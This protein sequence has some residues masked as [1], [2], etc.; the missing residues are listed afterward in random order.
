MMNKAE[1][2]KSASV[3]VRHVVTIETIASLEVVSFTLG[4]CYFLNTASK[5][6]IQ[7]WRDVITVIFV[8]IEDIII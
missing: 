5:F 6:V 1:W 4:H 3:T 7:A 8:V 2:Q